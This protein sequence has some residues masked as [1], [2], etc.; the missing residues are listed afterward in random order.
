MNI[1][2]ILSVIILI[3][4]CPAL[5]L[6]DRERLFQQQ[7][8]D[9]IA[10]QQRDRILRNAAELVRPS[11]VH[12]EA[13]K[14]VPADSQIG[15]TRRIEETGSGVLV[16]ID[17]R[18]FV[19]TNRHVVADMMLDS[20]RIHL[21][22]LRILTTN[23]RLLNQ[24]YDLALLSLEET[25]FENLMAARVGDSD[26]VD[27]ADTVLV[28]GSPFGLSGS[29]SVGSI[30]M[31]NRLR[32]PVSNQPNLLHGF[33][34]TDAAVNPGNSGG[35]MANV[36]GEVIALVTAIASSSGAHEGVAF[37]M[38]IKPLMRV[39]EELVR[40]GQATRPYIGLTTDPRFD[41]QERSR[42]GLTRSVGTRILQVAPDSPAMRA[43]I[44][45]GDVL[46]RF[47]GRDIEDD[48]HFISLIAAGQKGD[49]PV[50]MFL[51]Q[52]R[53]FETTPALGSQQSH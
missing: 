25:I 16:E 48:L 29:V 47:N 33:F 31:T 1:F 53:F 38:P 37:A 44:E 49:T 2:R 24:E 12:I 34:Q 14:S 10:L 6:A 36:R 19:L 32:I 13:V 23:G 52:G 43:G 11:V 26:E 9:A 51:R 35:P 50:I 28:F 17:N 30:S 27:I 18:F 40:T 8:Q 41:Q 22:D 5:A 46:I 3:A 39:A 21:H 7:Q 42:L 45:P 15:R 20:I 4:I